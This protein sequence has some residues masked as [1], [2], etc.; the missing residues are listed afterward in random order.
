MSPSGDRSRYAALAVAVAP[1][2][3][4]SWVRIRRLAP[5]SPELLASLSAIAAHWSADA[6]ASVAI[7][8]ARASSSPSIRAAVHAR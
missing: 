1:S 8:L 6:R 3:A 7:S 5:A 2:C 4:A